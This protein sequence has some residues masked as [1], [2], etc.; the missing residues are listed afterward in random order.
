MKILFAMLVLVA[1]LPAYGQEGFVDVG[2]RAPNFTLISTTGDTISLMDFR[3]MVV[4]LNFF[5]Y[6]CSTCIVD[7][8]YVQ[9]TWLQYQSQD[10]AVLGI[11]MKNDGETVDV[12]RNLFAIPTGA[13][14]PLLMTGEEVGAA[15]GVSYEF[16]F[17]IDRDGYVTLRLYGFDTTIVY[18]AIDRA[19][20]YT[21]INETDNRNIQ[22]FRL[23]QNFPNP[24]NPSTVIRFRLT[25]PGNVQLKI[26]NSAGQR[27]RTLIQESMPAGIHHIEWNSTNESGENVPSGIYY[28]QLNAGNQTL[29][30]KM[31]LIR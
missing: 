22:T 13:T 26:Y 29:T 31:T 23:E 9:I 7:G 8:P 10:V 17:V 21:E 24:F 20:I 28:Y 27:V 14:Y 15:Y 3:G 2:D 12:I 11:N 16:Y 30:R 25:N 5:G 1:V 4:L 19:L 18:E 6:D